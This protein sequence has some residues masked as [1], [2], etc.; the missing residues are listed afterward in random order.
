MA[1]VLSPVWVVGGLVGGEF[2]RV[3]G[4][5]KWPVSCLLV[6]A[7]GRFFGCWFVRLVVFGLLVCA[8]G[9][10]LGCWFVRLVV[11]GCLLVSLVDF[12]L[13]DCLYN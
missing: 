10:F 13:L 2:G 8:F 6:C 4:G 9:R 11:L 5:R 7:F 1:C 12:W 3:V